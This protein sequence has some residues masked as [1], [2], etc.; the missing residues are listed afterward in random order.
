[1]PAAVPDGILDLCH[2]R[3][4]PAVWYTFRKVIE[5]VYLAFA[6]SFGVLA[7]MF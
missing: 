1:M 5:A 6:A 3:R 4:E 7:V 2:T